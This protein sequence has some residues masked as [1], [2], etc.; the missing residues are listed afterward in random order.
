VSHLLLYGL[1]RSGLAVA[2]AA[3][4]RGDSILILDEASPENV[5]KRAVLESATREGFDVRFK[6]DPRQDALPGADEIVV[7]PAVPLRH[8]IHA[9]AAAVGIPGIGGIG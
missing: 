8:P 3:T 7:N 1:G 2:R 5:K 6:F 4:E 9:L